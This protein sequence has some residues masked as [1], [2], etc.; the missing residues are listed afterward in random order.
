MK[1]G[2]MVGWS[3]RL[4]VVALSLAIC[5]GCESEDTESEITATRFYVDRELR[6]YS[7]TDEFTWETTLN[8][9]V[10]TVRI[11]NFTEGDTTLRVYD[12]RGV[13]VQAA[14][15]DTLNS[16]YYVDWSLFYQRQ[17]DAGVA[18]TWRIVLSYSDFSGDISVTLE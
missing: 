13:L 12:G 11:N 5:G 17:T 4:A 14:L 7:S 8:Q 9:A 2:M 15:L 18:G 6:N 1:N 16:V 10:T 3:V